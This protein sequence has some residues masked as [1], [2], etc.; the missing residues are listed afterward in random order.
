[1]T[2]SPDLFRAAFDE[3]PHPSWIVDPT[4]AVVASNR[5]AGA[6]T[7]PPESSGGNATNLGDGPGPFRLIVAGASDFE[8]QRL[9]IL[10]MAARSGPVEDTLAAIASVIGNLCPG[11][12]CAILLLRNDRLTI[13]ASRRMSAGEQEAL[14][15]IPLSWL[16]AEPGVAGTLN[17]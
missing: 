12:P 6:G 8:Q 14:A 13:A 16:T 7:A 11:A 17:D 15:Q 4:G 2:A 5:A 10:E 9:A 1:M 3:N